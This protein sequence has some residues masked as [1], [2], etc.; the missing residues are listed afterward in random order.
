MWFFSWNK[1]DDVLWVL[2]D[3]IRLRS[4]GDIQKCSMDCEILGLVREN[5]DY[6]IGGYTDL[7]LI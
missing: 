6:Y 2:M 1:F 5:D 7:Q 4:W 3:L